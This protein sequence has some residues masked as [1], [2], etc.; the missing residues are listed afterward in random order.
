MCEGVG[1]Y[2][3]M[4]EGVGVYE[5]MCVCQCIHTSV[6]KHC[7]VGGKGAV[8]WGASVGGKGVVVWG[9]RTPIT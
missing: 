9:V 4:C 6:Y 1:V 3:V 7:G 2:E 5:V 8:V